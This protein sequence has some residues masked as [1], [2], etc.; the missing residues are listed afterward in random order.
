[1][2]ELGRDPDELGNRPSSDGLGL[3]SI[4][5][6]IIRLLGLLEGRT[7]LFTCWP[8]GPLDRANV[9]VPLGRVSS[10]RFCRHFLASDKSAGSSDDSNA[11]V[12]ANLFHGASW[13]KNAGVRGQYRCMSPGRLIK[14]SIL[15]V[16]SFSSLLMNSSSTLAY[17]LTKAKVCVLQIFAKS[18]K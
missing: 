16:K 11:S 7:D 13:I 6:S 12:R 4:F 10:L 8:P 15:I 17:A 9:V 5:Q 3:R 14:G 1:M 2:H 18:T